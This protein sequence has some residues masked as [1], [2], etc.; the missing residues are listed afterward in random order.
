MPPVASDYK[1]NRQ[2][3][4][5]LSL[6]SSL[7]ASDSFNKTVKALQ[8]KQQPW[9]WGGKRGGGGI[10]L[11]KVCPSEAP[12]MLYYLSITSSSSTTWECLLNSSSPSTK[13]YCSRRATMS[14][15]QESLSGNFQE[16]KH[17][18]PVL[19]NTSTVAPWRSIRSFRRLSIQFW[20]PKNSLIAG[21]DSQFL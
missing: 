3:S 12:F 20:L 11:S 6:L 1:T 9:S 19:E 17:T 21:K 2:A 10:L 16:E 14:R 7:V 4:S 15:L 8:K 5:L 18:G 13:S